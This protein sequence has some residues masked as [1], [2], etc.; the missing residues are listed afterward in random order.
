M[1]EKRTSDVNTFNGHWLFI[2]YKF[3]IY[4]DIRLNANNETIMKLFWN[5]TFA[6][7]IFMSHFPTLNVGGRISYNNIQCFWC[8]GIP[9]NNNINEVL[10]V[11]H[12]SNQTEKK[13][14]WEKIVSATAIPREIKTKQN[15][16]KK[17]K[18]MYWPEW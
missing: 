1:I 14:Q 4:F 6:S 10:V 16:I 15:K 5:S 17:L 8:L 18:L 13:C 2:S 12:E 9:I 3:A 11:A 7:N